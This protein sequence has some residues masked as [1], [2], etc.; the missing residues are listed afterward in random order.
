MKNTWTVCVVS[1]MLLFNAC[2]SGQPRTGQEWSV[3]A[4]SITDGDTFVA[5][6]DGVTFKVRLQGIDA[7]ERGQDFSKRSKERLGQLCS[8]APLRVRILNKDGFGRW[9]SEVY[10]KSGRHV[11]A[12]MVASGLAWHFKKYSQDPELDRLERVARKA[13]LGIWS[14]PN[15]QAPWEFRAARR[16][17]KKGR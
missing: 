11:N 4:V 13:L 2:G 17:G 14:L 16:S 8:N 1:C 3:M 6:G 12:E 10:D 15:P 9:V 7:P 5:R